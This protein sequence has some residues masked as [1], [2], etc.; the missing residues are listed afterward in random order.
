MRYILV[1]A[2]NPNIQKPIDIPDEIVSKPQADTIKNNYKQH[3]ITSS[4]PKSKKSK[5]IVYKIVQR[6]LPMGGMKSKPFRRRPS[7]TI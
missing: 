2:D 3:T 5:K 7:N 6:S 1:S 4:T